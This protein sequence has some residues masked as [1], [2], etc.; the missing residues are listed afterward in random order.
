MR[1]F[2]EKWFRDYLRDEVSRELVGQTGAKYASAVKECFSVTSNTSD[3]QARDILYEK[4][5]AVLEGCSA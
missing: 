4:V 1:Q 3:R 2:S 5:A